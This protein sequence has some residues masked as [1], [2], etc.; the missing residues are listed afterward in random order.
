[1]AVD[2]HKKS[3]LVESIEI[4]VL[5]VYLLEDDDELK[6]ILDRVVDEHLETIAI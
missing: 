4:Y 3:L 6:R 2:K 5:C 1:M